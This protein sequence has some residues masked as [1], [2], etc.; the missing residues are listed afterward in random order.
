VDK[1]VRKGL[2]TVC[3]ILLCGCG[4]IT[5][6]ITF[7]SE[8]EG[9]EISLNNDQGKIG[10]TPLE[11]YKV[12]FP[13]GVNVI[14]AEAIKEYFKPEKGYIYPTTNEVK[15]IL[16]PEK[17]KI[18]L[19]SNVKNTEIYLDGIKK[20]VCGP[21]L[22]YP[23]IIDLV[24]R[25]GKFKE[26]LLRA[27]KIGWVSIEKK[28]ITGTESI[29]SEI[30][31]QLE[32]EQK[33]ILIESVPSGADVIVNGEMIKMKT[34]CELSV[35]FVDKLSG[36][37]KK[38]KI[39]VAKA[40]YENPV[41]HSDT[42]S[43]IIEYF[44]EVTKKIKLELTRREEVDIPGLEILLLS[45]GAAMGIR[46]T[47][48]VLDPSED[49]PSVASCTRITSY[50][51]LSSDYKI[52]NAVI[53]LLFSESAT[54]EEFLKILPAQPGEVT[55][56]T[57]KELLRKYLRGII[58]PTISP[59][60]QTI[61]YSEIEPIFLKK[62]AIK[63]ELTT[64]EG[65][66]KKFYTIERIFKLPCN[67]YTAMS[68]K[69]GLRAIGIQGGGVTIVTDSIFIDKDPSIT[70]DGKYI[71][72][73]SSR[74]GDKFTIWRVK[75]EPPVGTGLTRIT[76]TVFADDEVN[77][78]WAT[79]NP[80]IVYSSLGPTANIYEKQIWTA[81]LDGTLPT[82]FRYGQNPKWSPDGKKIVFSRIDNKTGWYKIWIMNA[83]GTD[84][85]QLTFDEFD[86]IH[87]AFS[88][89]GKYIAYAST[90]GLDNKMRHNYDIWVMKSD[91]TM[92]TQLTTNGSEDIYPI[93]APDGK[94][95]YFVSNRGGCW[96]IW[97]I[98]IKSLPQ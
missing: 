32:P 44:P 7:N 3:L 10:K 86:D 92:K 6:E 46:K 28:I 62:E 15:F 38:I 85:T 26:Y 73:A 14:E 31:F 41:D 40:G 72:F 9:A 52:H 90:F 37:L 93:W 68:L 36:D 20:G 11:K 22:S 21:S 88:P 87:P 35:D 57:I 94:S 30:M 75:L 69:A 96:N 13:E 76:S 55:E 82:Q 49:S 27:S 58:S 79:E 66:T 24:D 84:Q 42:V 47:R 2:L 29:P 17:K 56:E 50:S 25:N 70:S 74:D 64:L 5:R 45:R 18:E 91:G 60:G 71:Y 23:L 34:P 43:Q 77:V 1:M 95:I 53:N 98:D 4:V 80:K 89:D 67:F 19:Y 16:E 48:A 33:R 54:I 51:P 81:N 39:E 8:P 63:E 12:R 59:D 78:S 97:K 61:V 83:D 65:R